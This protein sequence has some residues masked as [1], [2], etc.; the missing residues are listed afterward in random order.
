MA[1]ADDAEVVRVALAVA[2]EGLGQQVLLL[3]LA[4]DVRGRVDHALRREGERGGEDEEEDERGR[5]MELALFLS[6]AFS[7]CYDYFVC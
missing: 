3:Q 2:G 5:G 7:I 6:V 1:H 4:V